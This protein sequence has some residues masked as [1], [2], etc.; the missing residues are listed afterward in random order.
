MRNYRELARRISTQSEY[1]LSLKATAVYVLSIIIGIV[2]S[3]ATIYRAYP[4]M[5]A[6]GLFMGMILV[7]LLIG[8]AASMIDEINEGQAELYL[9]TGLSRLEYVASW[10]IVSVIYPIFAVFISIVLPMLIIDPSSLM[11]RLYPSST[12][13]VPTIL[14]FS[15]A[16]SIQLFNNTSLG[17]MFGLLSRKKGVAYLTVVF[18]G[19]I[20]PLILGI[21]TSMLDAITGQ[22]GQHQ[23][24]YLVMLPFNPLYS[25][26]I[27]SYGTLRLSESFILITPFITGVIS[28]WIILYHAKNDLEV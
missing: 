9:A 17:L 8:I 13:L 12:G 11:M 24:I 5:T 14:S 2:F 16:I 27:F 20:L 3:L 25:Y 22:Y 18:I 23:Y 7:I 26:M 21:I 19:F 10:Y 15:I 4:I 28:L 1:L 6:I